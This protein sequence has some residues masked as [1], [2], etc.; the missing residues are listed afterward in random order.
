MPNQGNPPDNDFSTLWTDCGLCCDGTMFGSVEVTADEAERLATHGFEF[1]TD[2]AGD[3]YFRQRCC[4]LKG[5]VCGVYADRPQ[6]CREYACRVLRALED[7]TIAMPEARRRVEAVLSYRR[8]LLRATGADS[9]P[10]A[11]RVVEGARKKRD[12]V[13]AAF[14]LFGMEKALDDWFR[15][16][17]HKRMAPERR[18]DS[19]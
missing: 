12:G 3:R 14:A 4:A 9:L 16:N 1:Q 8:D 18:G 5:S 17:K 13:E 10:Q 15:I 19:G 2:E 11:F 7:S 6:R